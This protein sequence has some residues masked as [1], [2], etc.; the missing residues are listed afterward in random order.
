MKECITYRNLVNEKCCRKGFITDL[1]PFLPTVVL[2]A[3]C[4][5]A[6]S[7]N[8]FSSLPVYAINAAVHIVL[9]KICVEFIVKSKALF[10]L[11][12]WQ[13]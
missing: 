3:S 1:R 11:M 8:L 2:R 13:S 7:L 5:R 12:F 6:L 10:G 4:N 9:L